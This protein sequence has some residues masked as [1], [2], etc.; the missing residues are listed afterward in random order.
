MPGPNFNELP[1]PAAPFGQFGEIEGRDGGGPGD[2][3]GDD[4]A[5]S[6]GT[7]ANHA[8]VVPAATGGWP[9]RA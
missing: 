5:P 9:G 6:N 8:D 3:D 2:G 4:V 1:E 7:P